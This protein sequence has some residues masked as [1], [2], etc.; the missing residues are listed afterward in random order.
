L[1]NDRVEAAAV[2]SV[3]AALAD[4]TRVRVLALSDGEHA[5]GAIA[6]ELGV[7]SSAVTHHVGRLVEVGLVAVVRRGRQRCPLAR[8]FE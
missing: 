6:A 1:I 8:A 3:A 7:T 5:I 4:L 2:A